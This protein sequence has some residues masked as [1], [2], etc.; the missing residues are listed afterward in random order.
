MKTNK[1]AVESL[2]SY[3]LQQDHRA[4]CRLLANLM[5]DFRRIQNIEKLPIEERNHL[6]DRMSH[7]AQQLEEFIEKGPNGPLNL[8]NKSYE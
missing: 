5:I 2:I 4:V 7:N 6:I 1:E 8:E 3:F